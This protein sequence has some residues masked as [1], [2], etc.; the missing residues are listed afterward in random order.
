MA[1][2]IQETFDL[3][4]R[5]PARERALEIACA[6]LEALGLRIADRRWRIGDQERGIVAVDGDECVFCVL[7]DEPE[8]F[9]PVRDR[10]IAPRV[11]A[12]AWLKA[13]RHRRRYARI[14]FDRLAVPLTGDGQVVGLEHEPDAY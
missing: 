6:H 5:A 3:H 13:A 12:I 2:T 7:D 4:A 11:A 14:R 8:L 1:G 9:R 10:W